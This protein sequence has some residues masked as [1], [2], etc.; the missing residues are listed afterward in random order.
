MAKSVEGDKHINWIIG[1][2]KKQT[3][4]NKV[5]EGEKSSKKNKISVATFSL[6]DSSDVLAKLKSQMDKK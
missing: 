3:S 1:D 4:I 6:G 2:I 5:K